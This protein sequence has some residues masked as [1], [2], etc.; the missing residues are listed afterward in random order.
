M[1]SLSLLLLAG[2]VLAAQ[3]ALAEDAPA[4]VDELVVTATRLPTP[5]SL[6]P[7]ARVI[8]EDQIVQSGAVFAPDALATVPGL[9]VFGNG[10]AGGVASVRIRGAE[11]D[12]T[13]VLIDGVPVNDPSQPDGNFDF[14]T[15]N[16]ADVERIEI[17]SGPQGSLW[18][19]SAIGGV[20]AFTTREVDGVRGEVEAG[21]METLRGNVAVGEANAR[22]A[23]SASAAG[24]HTGGI[25]RAD[26]AD[27]NPERDA[28]D[29]LT[30][31]GKG[32]LAV[33]DRVELDGQLRYERARI[34]QDGFPAPFFTLA[35][36]E[37]VSHNESWTGFARA[38]L[39]AA[40]MTHRF[41]LS[42]YQLDREITGG[43]F[44][45]R[46]TTERRV[47]RW[48]SERLVEDGLSFV[49]G[50]EREDSEGDV[51]VGRAEL[52]TTSAFAVAQAKPFGDVAITGSLRYDD[53][54][55]FDGETTARLAAVAPI[56]AGFELRASWGQGFKTPTISQTVC[57]FCF[58]VPE[59][60][61]LRPERAE[62]WDA[63]IAWR[64][65]DGRY[66]AS[67]T[68]YGL[69]VRDQIA[70]VFD[71]VTFESAYANLE[72]TRTRGV[73]AEASAELGRGFTLRL[74][75][76]YTDAED[77]TTGEPL[78]RQP[79]HQ[80]SAV[81]A[82]QGERGRAA[83]T[84]RAESSQLDVLDFGRARRP[85][86][87]TAD[88]TGGW[89]LSDR[90]EATVRVENLL[91]RRYQEVL[92]YGEPGISAFVGLRLLR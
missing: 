5:V 43:D 36:T 71:P 8:T 74:G 90:L 11:A 30:L 75:Y 9:S 49:A 50:A 55:E 63:G 92:G 27:G 29:D 23:L 80:G 69:E 72:Q 15:L 67:V 62:G 73:E 44:P 51:S 19:S 18:G 41:S 47:W 77:Q 35:D 31:S 26:S 60:T 1:R 12:K 91:D 25:S 53:P 46:F 83:L 89:K 3:P 64:S 33:T 22:Y 66:A 81:L 52:G 82:W 57:D 28:F 78:L 58:P 7:G 48:T 34:E 2:G 38:K 32:R 59:V 65:G 84:V 85:G 6:S 4:P 40:G 87:V 13:L 10:P 61:S 76:G 20:I 88:L 21:S 68:V 45:S 37:E 56:G 70:F 54:D 86:F 42:H 79:L 14:G 16:L 24:F 39:K 17:L